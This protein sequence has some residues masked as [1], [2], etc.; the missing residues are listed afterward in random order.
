MSS[1]YL[2]HWLALALLVAVVVTVAPVPAAFGQEDGRKVKTRVTPVY[3]ELAKRMNVNGTVKIQ[4]TITANGQVK[5][6][7]VVG[8]HPLLVD[9]ALDAVKKWKFE[10]ASGET[11][12]TIVFNFNSK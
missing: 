5:N 9:S 10:S 4:V 12:Q 7:T 6:T 2:R 11:T 1:R 3:P 8:G